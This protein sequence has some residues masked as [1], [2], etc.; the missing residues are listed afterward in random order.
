MF[1]PVASVFVLVALALSACGGHDKAGGT[2]RQGSRTIEVVIRDGSPR[3]LIAYVNSVAHLSGKSIRVRVRTGW[4]AQDPN[5]EA[6]AIADVRAGRVRFALVSARAL[7]TLGV[8]AFAP[9]LAPLAID[10]LE[11]ERRVLA[12][13]LPG[14][15]LPALAKLGVVGVTVLPGD[16]RHPLGLTR[17]L[18]RPQ[19]FDGALIGVRASVLAK[20]TFE[21]LGASVEYS[22][23]DDFTPF[24]GI[25][26]DLTSLESVRA[27]ERAL[28]LAVGVGLWPRMLVLVANREAWEALPSDR[29]EALRHAGRAALP[30]AI[31]LLH[32]RDAEAYDV[33]CRRGQVSFASVTRADLEALRRS[34][35]PVV[36]G[37]D[38]ATLAEIARLRQS[39]GAP[40]GHPPCRLPANASAGPRTPVDGVW[41]F[42]SDQ[43]DLRAAMRTSDSTDVVPENWGH[44][45]LAF[46]RGRFVITQQDREACTWVYGTYRVRGP[47]MIWDVTDGGGY[48]PSNATNRPGEHFEYAWSR[49]KDTLHL[50]HVRDAISGENFLAKPWRQIGDDPRRAPLSRRCPPPPRALQF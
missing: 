1:R 47:R 14:R 44:H 29:R 45:V 19:D 24:D 26:T 40:P 42:D 46:S 30:A 48:S 39:A 28:S 4:R 2:A 22:A 43:E 38:P 31:E 23:G 11:A 15:A 17:P 35:A 36:R 12:S 27:D 20:R 25:E 49:F 13:D 18:L 16:I 50:T 32:K 9:M 7:D 10:S 3:H 8:T 37:L 34:L 5:P 6:R 21:R 33:L 41:T